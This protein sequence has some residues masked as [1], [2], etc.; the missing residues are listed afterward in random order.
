MAYSNLDL[1]ISDHRIT[2]NSE[3]F[4]VRVVNSPIG[5]QASD[6]VVTMAPGLRNRVDQLVMGL[7]S[8]A[9]MI[10][11]GEELGGLLFPPVARMYLVGSQAQLE[12]EERLRVRLWIRAYSLAD[13]PWEYSYVILPGTVSGT[14]GMDGFLV[15]NRSFSLVRYGLVGEAPESLNPIGDGAVR[16][17]VLMAS[18]KGTDYAELDLEKEKGRIE[19]ALKTVPQIQPEFFLHAT[20]QDLQDALVNKAHIFHF[21]GHGTFK[22]DAQADAGAQGGMGYL[23]LENGNRGMRPF[24]SEDLILH[25]RE[26]GVRLA[27]LGACEGA[28]HDSVNPWS[29]VAPALIRA[30]VPAVVGMQYQI[31][32]ASAI[33][34][35]Q[36]LYGTLAAGQSIDAAVT[37]GRL[38]LRSDSQKYACDWG[39][40]ALYLRADEGTLFPKPAQ[41]KPRP[42]GRTE[43]GKQN[44]LLDIDKRALRTVLVQNFDL[45]EL[46]VL[47]ADVELALQDDGIPLQ[48]NLEM[49]G[50][51]SKVGK[52][53][54]LIGYLDR[55][56]YL[57]YLVDAMRQRP[58]IDL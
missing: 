12:D 38:A 44:A 33:T 6:E 9:D 30:G 29:G 43:R 18:P 11:V 46:A 45:V 28:R 55:R 51:S 40:P 14:K 16:M 34:F 4:S 17:V 5:Q 25:L 53:L 42:E 2:E 20:V 47:C 24:P 23:I 15:L 31:S 57:G 22:P 21:F 13:L 56:G 1:E 39:I 36:G 35:S 26:S 50:G 27:V 41:S 3:R 58:D 52:V 37:A 19:Q 48:V 49:V 54:N 32:D 8:R 10:A 7:L